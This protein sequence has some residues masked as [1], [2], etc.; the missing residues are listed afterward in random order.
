[1]ELTI[2]N[3]PNISLMSLALSPMYLSTIALDTTLRKL[4]SNCF[5]TALAR[6]VFPVPG[7]PYRR[8]PLGG[9]IPT[10]PNNSGL[11]RGSSITCQICTVNIIF[12]N[13][14]VWAQ[15]RSDMRARITTSSVHWCHCG[16]VIT[17]RPNALNLKWFVH[18]CRTSS[19][20]SLTL[21]VACAGHMHLWSK[22]L[23][24]S[25]YMYMYVHK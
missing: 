4:A 20:L 3:V 19:G 11:S 21:H 2:E 18:A 6:R 22:L 9:V 7:A 8:Q 13:K 16:H 23:W 12:P 24:G 10:R 1:M 17:S 25:T 15:R 5:E 14:S